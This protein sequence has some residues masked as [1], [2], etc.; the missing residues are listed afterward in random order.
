MSESSAAT[1][2]GHHREGFVK[3]YFFSLDHK[4]I[5]RQFLFTGM[6][7]LVIGGLLAMMV[8]W[9]LGYPEEPLPFMGGFSEDFWD[10]ES[11]WAQTVPYGIVT[12]EFYNTLFTM[13]AT[14]MIFFVVMPIMVGGFG[15]FLI[16]IC[17]GA[18][19]MAFPVLNMLSYWTFVPGVLL[20]LL[21]FF[22]PGGAAGGGWTNYAPL[23]AVPDYAGVEGHWGVTLWCISLFI[24]G[25]SSLMGSINYITTII[26][27]RAPGMTLF[28]MPLTVWSL[29]IVAILLLLALPVLTSALAMMVFDRMFGTH[30]FI[31]DGGGEPLLWQHL[32]WFFGHPEVYILVLPAMGVT[33]DVL[34]V[35]ARKPIFGYRAMV[36][37]M[38][39]IA[40][41]SW[42]VWGHHM[43]QSGM[44]PVLGTAFTLTTMLIAVPSAIKTFNWLGTLCGS[45]IRFTTAMWFALGFVSLFTIGGPERHLHGVDAGG[46]LHPRHVLHRGPYPLRGRRHHLRCF[47]RAVFLVPENVRA[48]DERDAGQAALPA[49][50]RVLQPDVLPHALPG[51]RRS[52]AAHLQPD[53]V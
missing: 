16:P 53:A 4:M 49:H 40:F 19:D 47:L 52:H 9:Q 1:H 21:S 41:L 3:H 38:C 35:F 45:S 14:I 30:F 5:G 46:Y 20:M 12:S 6:F 25:F 39:A 11:W 17:I 18:K 37:S 31:P 7:M 22:V 32:F 42:V 10:G 34:S 44:D 13:H 26:N 24:I 15:N 29:F 36:Y 50:L 8:R 51:G 28:R 23:A 2:A 33:S 48:H 43:F 27:M